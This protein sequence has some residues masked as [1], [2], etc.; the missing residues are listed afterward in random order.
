MNELAVANHNLHFFLLFWTLGL[1]LFALFENAKREKKNSG[2][3]TCLLLEMLFSI[4]VAVSNMGYSIRS[5]FF[6]LVFIKEERKKRKK[7]EGAPGY[8]PP[9][10]H[11]LTT[12]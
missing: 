5:F 8:I 2:I 11:L 4:T 3:L 7:S 6:V 1:A 9:H 12:R 10:T